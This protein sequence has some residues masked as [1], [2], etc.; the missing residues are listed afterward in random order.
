MKSHQTLI[1]RIARS[2]SAFPLIV[3]LSFSAAAADAKPGRPMSNKEF[4][5]PTRL[6]EVQI[7]MEAADFDKLRKQKR[8]LS[9]QFSAAREEKSDALPKVYDWFKADVT[10]DG[11][12]LKDVKI[13]KRGLLGSENSDRPSFNIDLPEGAEFAGETRVVLHNNNQD[14]SNVQQLL[15]YE[16]LAA[17]GVPAPRCNLACVTVNGKSLGIYSH[18]EAVDKPFLKRHFGSAKGNLYEAAISDFRPGWVN[19]FEVKNNKKQNDRSDLNRLVQALERPEG[20]VSRVAPLVDIDAYLSFWAGEALIGHWDGFTGN[21]NN[22]FVYHDPKSDK[23]RFIVWGADA[24]FGGGNVFAPFEYPVSVMALSRL[25][26]RL[27]DDAAIRDQYQARMRKLLATAWNEGELLAEVDRVEKLIRPRLTIPVPLFEKWLK[28]VR[29]FIANRRGQINAELSGR[30][31]P[32]LYPDRTAR[33]RDG[34]GNLV[35]SFSTTWSTNIFGAELTNFPAASTAALSLDFYGRKYSGSTPRSRSGISL[36]HP[37]WVAI[38]IA[39]PVE[40]LSAPIVVTVAIDRQRL[41][42]GGTIP[43]DGRNAVG[44]LLLNEPSQPWYRVL[45]FLMNPSDTVTIERAGSG[46]GEEIRGSVN[47]PLTA[48]PWEDFDLHKL[49]PD[50][51]P[52][53]LQ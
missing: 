34:V 19:T 11:I 32:W 28:K 35:A 43:L 51:A 44:Y 5:A 20:A 10:I 50:K 46:V 7:T 21:A 27:Y 23:F 49:N 42:Q 2:L 12:T 33:H 29:A 6:L 9:D 3:S 31:Q 40:G 38:Q 15:G 13:R 48:L 36:R 8:D 17:A 30:S 45:A 14:P 53:I 39:A 47:G 24:T 18:I 37:T 26:R 4:F 22:C 41:L 52:V 1:K 16:V 25:S